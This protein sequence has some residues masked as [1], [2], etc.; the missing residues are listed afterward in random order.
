MTEQPRFELYSYWRTSATYRVRVALALKGVARRERNV[1]VDAGEQRSEAFLKLNPLGG[2]PVLVDLQAP[3]AAPLTQSLAILEF[4]EESYPTPALLPAGLHARARVRSIAGMCTVDTH[5][6][7]TPRVR[8]YLA[9][10][11]RF[12]D[13]AWRA[14]QT[15]WFGTG[16]RAVEQ[17]LAGD[18]ATGTYCHGETVSLAD[19]CLASIIAVMRVFKIE[20]AG[21]PTVDRIMAACEQLEAFR[22]AE[23]RRQAGA[24]PA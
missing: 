16:L 7:I 5:P 23:P 9:G 12:D 4:L 19:I 18:A 24:P 15:H 11:G 14:W 17:R 21:I 8:K 22:Q 1:D 10:E 3:G 13:A 6:L 20:V 2:L